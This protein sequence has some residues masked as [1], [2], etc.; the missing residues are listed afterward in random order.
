MCFR[1]LRPVALLSLGL[2]SSL[3][4]EHVWK[5]VA[6]KGGGFVPGI[7]FHPETPGILYA[8]TDVGGIYRWNLADR[9]WTP[10]NDELRGQDNM[11][12]LYGVLSLA[13]DPQN[14]RKVYIACG[15]YLQEEDWNPSGIF[16]S[17][18]SGL[19]WKLKSIGQNVKF[20][21]N[22]DGRN[23][24][25]RLLVDP[26]NGSV[27]YMGTQTRGL[28]K[29]S[30]GGDRWSSLSLPG[31]S[32][33]WIYADA[34]SATKGEET[35]LLYAFAGNCD[36]NTSRFSDG[37]LYCSRDAG[38]SWQ[39]IPGTPDGLIFHQAHVVNGV[40]YATL[41]DAL[42]PN[43]ISRGCLAKLDLSTGVWNKLPAPAGQ[44]GFSGLAVDRHNPDHM[45]VGTLSRWYPHNEIYRTVDG[46]QTWQTL[47]D[48]S[49][50]DFDNTPY[51]EEKVPHWITD[52]ELDP[53]DSNHAIFVTGYGI[54]E[55][56][57][58]SAAD[59]GGK[60]KWTFM[61]NGLEETVPLEL[62]SPL[63]GAPLVSA[64]G[65][66]DGFRHDDLFA[67]PAGGFHK[68][69]GGTSPS[70]D[71]AALKPEIMVR[72]HWNDKRGSCSTDGGRTWSLFET[73]PND[74][75]P[76]YVSISADAS[77]ILFMSSPQDPQWM[78][79]EARAKLVNDARPRYSNDFGKTWNPV[80]GLPQ[81]NWHPVADPVLPNTF[82]VY[83]GKNGKVYRS[84]D[85]GARFT[86][87][88]TLQSGG[89]KIT[90]VPGREGHLF[91]PHWNCLYFSDNGGQSFSK[92][93]GLDNTYEVA[94]GAPLSPGGDPALY[95]WAKNHGSEGI[96]MSA[97][98]GKTWEQI[99]NNY[100]HFGRINTMAADQNV[101]GRVYLGTGGRGIVVGDLP[102]G[103]Y[104]WQ[105]NHYNPIQRKEPLLSAHYADPD[106]NGYDNYMEYALATD[107]FPGQPPIRNG[108]KTG[109]SAEDS[110]YVIQFNKLKAIDVQDYRL[111]GSQDG[112]SWATI[113][114]KPEWIEVFELDKKT[115]SVIFTFPATTDTKGAQ[116]VRVYIPLDE[117]SL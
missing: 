39:E 41:C 97:D 12:F 110:F 32:V 75:A 65:D 116:I 89:G 93:Q 70:V 61:C 42:G 102:G 19:A 8:R 108:V 96:Y 33:T 22:T 29:S 98:Y 34:E 66:I 52:I 31:N 109:T 37:K 55:T 15:S 45:V 58:L 73:A 13:L 91:I 80:E 85:G 4:A 77:S 10:L 20:G 83:C 113:P 88:K 24:A 14:A 115:E 51:V 11:A 28:F 101:P 2:V 27:L 7:V 35:P 23:T 21:G 92:L 79:E 54:F 60:V 74:A 3:Q 30:N 112:I 43:G 38:K 72:S 47:F 114:I 17:D 1:F 49:E 95:V 69:A 94:V 67:S 25:E 82:Y 87:T 104:R 78:S 16:A 6:I 18:S 103:F 59:S 111:Q 57:N 71:Y 81:G 63:V 84:D 9:S 99:N 56:Y 117:R 105:Q 44:G 26:N 50:W 40:L 5:N 36:K 48:V 64:I 107:L 46:G 53:F 68:P 62:V 106:L 86:V 100:Q 90:A 76:G